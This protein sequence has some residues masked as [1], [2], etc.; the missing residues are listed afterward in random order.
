MH[1]NRRITCTVHALSVFH[2]SVAN[3]LHFWFLLCINWKEF[4]ESY[5]E[6]ISQR[7]LPNACFRDQ[8]ENQDGRL[9]LLFYFKFSTSSLQPVNGIQRNLTRRQISKR[10]LL[11]LCFSG[12]TI[13][14]SRWTSFPLISTSPLQ[15]LIR[16]QW[17]LTRSKISTFSAKF[18]FFFF[19]FFFL[20]GGGGS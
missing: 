5:Q 7:P 16:I 11:S 20:G 4:N 6:A 10:P 1:L 2:P 14:K 18:F 15:L 12:R 13:R 8:S 19:F 9:G 17:N 3:F